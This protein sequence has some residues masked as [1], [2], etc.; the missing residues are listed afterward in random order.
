MPQT[1]PAPEIMA[2]E[3]RPDSPC[4][5]YCSTTLGDTV[6]R[7]CGRTS[8]EVDQ[9]ILLPEHQKQAIWERI[10]LEDTIR[11]RYTE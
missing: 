6:C 11:N 3:H 1:R 8:S 9:W 5:G 4:I 7:G 10:A 2:D